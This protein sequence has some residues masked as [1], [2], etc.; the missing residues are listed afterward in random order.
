MKVLIKCGIAQGIDKRKQEH[1]KRNMTKPDVY[2]A[3]W[4][5]Q[6]ISFLE[7]HARVI[8]NINDSALIQGKSVAKRHLI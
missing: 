6:I 7:N 5:E 1:A 8:P 3:L 4:Q 2:K